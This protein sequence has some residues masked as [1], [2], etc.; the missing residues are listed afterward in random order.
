MAQIYYFST[1]NNIFPWLSKLKLNQFYSE[2][3]TILFFILLPIKC[4][5]VYTKN[6]ILALTN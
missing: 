2:L 4:C 1:I 5:F 6:I 3:A